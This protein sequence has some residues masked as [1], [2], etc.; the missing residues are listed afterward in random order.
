VTTV[1]GLIVAVL[2]VIGLVIIGVPLYLTCG[3]SASTPLASP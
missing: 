2:D 3:V 1:F